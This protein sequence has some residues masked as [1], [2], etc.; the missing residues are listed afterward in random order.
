M[1]K[2]INPEEKISAAL[3]AFLF[4]IPLITGKRTEFVVFYMKQNFALILI[5]ILFNIIVFIPFI[6][7]FI[8]WVG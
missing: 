4:F 3:G 7:T 6:G 5:S 1:T 2:V 8:Y